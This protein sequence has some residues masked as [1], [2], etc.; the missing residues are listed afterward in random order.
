MRRIHLPNLLRCRNVSVR[1][2]LSGTPESYAQFIGR[3][4]RGVELVADPADVLDDPDIDFLVVANRDRQHAEWVLRAVQAGKH[5]YCEKPLATTW[6]ECAT[7]LEGLDTSDRLCSVGFNRRCAP[8]VQQAI[9]WFAEAGDR[10]M[11]LEYVVRTGGLSQDRWVFDPRWGAGPIIGEACHFIDF[12]RWLFGDNPAHVSATRLGPPVPDQLVQDLFIHLH[13]TGG[14]AAVIRYCA[15]SPRHHGKEQITIRGER[16]V[17]EISDFRSLVQLAPTERKCQGATQDK[18][19]LSLLASF[20][21]A[22]QSGGTPPCSWTDGIWATAL[23][24]LA[25]ESARTGQPIGVAGDL[26]MLLAAAALS[27]QGGDA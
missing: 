22:V 12:A 6:D 15:E 9:A 14:R 7:L 18:G 26:R 1:K 5:V 25:L 21:E 13:F 23:A 2:L 10:P 24:L 27:D 4:P 19:H 16:M 11:L 20:I 17:V 8:L 3:L